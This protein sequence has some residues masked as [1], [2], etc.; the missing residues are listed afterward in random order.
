MGYSSYLFKG[1]KV[2]LIFFV[3]TFWAFSINFFVESYVQIYLSSN[4]QTDWKHRIFESYHDAT[5]MLLLVGFGKYDIKEWL[6]YANAIFFLCFGF[7][8]QLFVYGE[9][10]PIINIG[11]FLNKCLS[12]NHEI[13]I[14]T[15]TPH[16]IKI[17][18]SI[19]FNNI[20]FKPKYCKC[21]QN[22]R[23]RRTNTILSISS[24]KNT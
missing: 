3:V 13:G 5:L 15:V 16:Y 1:I 23:V 21:G 22:M 20:I 17:F 11:D 8:L 2:I 10:G 4:K 14:L 7:A 18:L 9:F 6:E 12:S 19:S 24:S